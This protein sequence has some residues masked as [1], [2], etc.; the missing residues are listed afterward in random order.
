[1]VTVGRMAAGSALRRGLL[2]TSALTV[3]AATPALAIDWLG[4]TS[5]QW[6]LGSN[7]SGGTVPSSADD[8]AIDLTSPNA[9]NISGG[10]ANTAQLHVGATGTGTLSITNGATASVSL[11]SVGT[12]FGATGTVTV[13]GAGS[14]LTALS[15][16]LVGNAGTGTLN[17]RNG[18]VVSG[19]FQELYIGNT[20]T[21]SGTVNV[22]GAGS[23]LNANTS[24]G[25]GGTGVLN[26]TNGGKVDNGGGNFEVGFQSGSNGTA[27]VSGA[28]SAITAY[29]VYVG[30]IGTGTLTL[31]NGG[32]IN[33]A[34]FYIGGNNIFATG[35]GTVNI[36][37]ASGSAAVAPGQ[38]NSAVV[39]FGLG[40]GRLVF[41]H[42]S[43][44][45][46]FAPVIAGN[47]EV[48]V[49]AG[50]TILSAANT[51]TGDTTINGGMLLV[52]GSTNSSGIVFVNP[53]GTLGGTGSVGSV[54][55]D[56]R[57]TLAP[58]LPNSIGTLT[59]DGI[60]MLCNC[61]TYL[62]KA[63][64]LG[65]ADKA[66]VTGIA[67]IDGALKIAPTTWIGS[68]TNYTVLSASG[69]INGDFASGTVTRPWLARL[70]GWNVVGNDMLVTLDRGS[71]AAALPA[72]ATRNAWA[73]GTGIENALNGG[74]TPS[75]Q[76]TN[77]MSLS[78]PALTNALN[79]AAG[80]AGTGQ[81]QAGYYASNQF[82][83]A[84]FDQ[85]AFGRGGNARGT[86]MGYASESDAMAYAPKRTRS[87]R[88]ALA[89]VAAKAP[90]YDLFD[91]RWSLWGT[92]Y[93]GN[94]S[95]NGNATT[96]ASDTISRAYGIA[97]GADYTLSRDTTL[98]FALGGGGS[99]FAVANGLGSGSADTIQAGVFGKHAMGAAYVS[100]GL[101]YTY[102]D[103]TTNRTVT[104]AGTDRLQAKFNANI[105]AG[106][107][108]GGY[109]YALP[110]AGITPY[111]ALQ[112]TQINLPSYAETVLAGTGGF[113]LNYNAKDT[114]IARTE[115]GARFDRGFALNDSLLTLRGRLAWAHDEG[116]T[117]AVSA[118]FASLP[119][120][121]FTVNG[122]VPSKDLALVSAG[123][124][125]KWMNNISLSATFEGEFSNTTVG[126][127][128]KGNLRYV[129]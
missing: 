26:V 125:M 105:F 55:V 107:I 109:R 5:S 85:F 63:D 126:Y 6:T 15:Y 115:L 74:G 103:V 39:Q 65:N 80:E 89:A 118:M 110:F 114:T 12:N 32:A 123:A 29:G 108:E 38:I 54:F 3:F 56:D 8:V 14:S 129:W 120:S 33:S 51:Y 70:V 81:Q 45:Y 34:E 98:G 78:G 73:A 117:A 18:G 67:N 19:V 24:V 53:G 49:E 116:N 102:Q 27:T 7:W 127:A 16:L 57:A 1:M 93:G 35:D 66:S 128:G 90:R 37:A 121:T 31:S 75:A 23:Q 10:V 50:T 112:V 43:Q 48:I 47:G 119:G 52:N 28:G 58:G 76:M 86:A 61:S 40:T 21:G 62:V 83:N 72:N 13:D 64:N 11:F 99:S 17:I 2:T 20:A 4:T 42:T 60:L 92:A 95:T 79:Q 87:E 36:G 91:P 96:G 84:M 46:N 97:A 59:I 68:A 82:M 25:Y 113:A 124:E 100:G 111:A 9:P 22:D 104:I 122:A 94:S 30:Y 41:N 101:S 77:L 106:R 88:E 69:G 71:L 44:N